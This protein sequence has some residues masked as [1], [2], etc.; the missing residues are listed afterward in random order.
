MKK[1]YSK[2]ESKAIETLLS[3]AAVETE[4]V[5]LLEN[6]KRVKIKKS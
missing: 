1:D 6:A 3:G 5:K 2:Q 4:V